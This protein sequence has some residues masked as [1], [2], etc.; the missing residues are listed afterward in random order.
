MTE[1][2]ACSR[3][4]LHHTPLARAKTCCHLDHD[5]PYLLRPR[6]TTCSAS[7]NN[8]CSTCS[9]T[10]SDGFIDR[11]KEQHNRVRRTSCT[12]CFERLPSEE[13]PDSFEFML[14]STRSRREARLSEPPTYRSN[15][16]RRLGC[17]CHSWSQKL[18]PSIGTAGKWTGQVAVRFFCCRTLKLG[19][20]GPR[21][22]EPQ[23]FWPPVAQSFDSLQRSP[24]GGQRW[25]G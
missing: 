4:T 8:A 9:R 6:P 2:Q 14:S 10:P 20:P 15:I 7:D 24:T 1:E 12:E 23:A 13:R 19:S 11:D 3:T 18:Y 16:S 22:L 17:F 21:R 5:G 25:C